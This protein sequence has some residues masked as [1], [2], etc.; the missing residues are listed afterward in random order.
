MAAKGH[1]Y[2]RPK[3]TRAQIHLRRFKEA[4]TGF[5]KLLWHLNLGQH[6]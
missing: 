4:V 1:E 2:T 6:T 3:L 5:L